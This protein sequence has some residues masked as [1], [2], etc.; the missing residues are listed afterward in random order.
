MLSEP[1]AAGQTS[2]QT[3]DAADQASTTL[4]TAAVD[5]NG[6]V[7]RPSATAWNH[8][9]EGPTSPALGMSS[10]MAIVAVRSPS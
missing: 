3:P 9:D 7:L 10:G 1:A 4:K 2:V 5:P 6:P 8:T